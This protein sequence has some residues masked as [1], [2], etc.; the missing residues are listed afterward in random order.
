M[1][2][3]DFK[4]KDELFYRRDALISMDSL[5]LRQRQQV[6]LS[7]ATRDE[8]RN[9][10]RGDTLNGQQTNHTRDTPVRANLREECRRQRLDGLPLAKFAVCLP[11]PPSA[12]IFRDARCTGC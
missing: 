7:I 11:A 12:R 4:L 3:N 1:K 6:V 5:E 2:K 9:S 10:H 8:A